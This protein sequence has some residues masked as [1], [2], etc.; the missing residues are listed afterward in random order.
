MKYL[1]PILLLATGCVT[2]RVSGL[3][4]HEVALSKTA[5]NAGCLDAFALTTHFCAAPSGQA[6]SACQ[7]VV[8]QICKDHADLYERYVNSDPNSRTY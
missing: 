8:D 7:Q 4:E 1:L 3:T 6:S 2:A 5:F